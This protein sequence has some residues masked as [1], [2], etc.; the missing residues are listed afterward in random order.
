MMELTMGVLDFVRDVLEAI[1]A[2][3]T[4]NSINT[5]IIFSV[6]SLLCMAVTTAKHKTEW[7]AQSSKLFL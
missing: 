5:T 2:V 1:K 6:I 7:Q 3:E 4:A